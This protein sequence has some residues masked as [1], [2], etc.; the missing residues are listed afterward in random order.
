MRRTD[1]IP[2]ADPLEGELGVESLVVLPPSADWPLAR[3]A[4]LLVHSAGMNATLCYFGPDLGIALHCAGFRFI[5][6]AQKLAA[7]VLQHITNHA[8]G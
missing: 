3:V 6:R 4:G 2:V 5:A 1:L 7:S 8:S